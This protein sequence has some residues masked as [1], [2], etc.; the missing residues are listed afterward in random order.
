MSNKKC[1]VIL[2]LFYI[3][4]LDENLKYLSN[5]P[6]PFDLHVST[7]FENEAFVKKS[8]LAI[9]PNAEIYTVD[10]KGKYIAPFFTIANQVDLTQYDFICKIHTKK[11]LQLCDGNSWRKDLYDK[12]LGSKQSV[13]DIITV[14]SKIR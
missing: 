10:N 5:I 11:S 6:I 14:F 7:L 8:I 9:Y 12:L 13:L 2:H 4:L 1:A 3:D